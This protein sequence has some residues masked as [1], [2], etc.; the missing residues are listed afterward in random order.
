[1]GVDEERV[2]RGVRRVEH[3]IKGVWGWSIGQGN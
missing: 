2:G 3:C 1:M